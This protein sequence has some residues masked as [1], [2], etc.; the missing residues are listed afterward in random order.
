[1]FIRFWTGK[2]RA[3]GHF[4]GH[5]SLK[6]GQRQA[7]P[8]ASKSEGREQ[9]SQKLAQTFQLLEN[10]QLV[11]LLELPLTLLVGFLRT[12]CMWFGFTDRVINQTPGLWLDLSLPEALSL[13][14]YLLCTS[15]HSAKSKNSPSFWT[16]LVP[17]LPSRLILKAGTQQVGISTL[18]EP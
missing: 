15:R 9:S 12:K 8:S 2:L 16:L 7:E 13:S 1:M 11:F 6:Q 14:G 18:S 5:L 17:A 4:R 3:I 10:C